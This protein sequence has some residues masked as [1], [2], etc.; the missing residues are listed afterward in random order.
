MFNISISFQFVKQQ[1]KRILCVETIPA[2]STKLYHFVFR[3]E[4]IMNFLLN[5]NKKL[6]RRLLKLLKPL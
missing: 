6:E 3:T 5:G 4:F 1:D 2:K